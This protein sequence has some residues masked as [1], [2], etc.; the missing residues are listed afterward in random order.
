[1]AIAWTA[2]LFVLAG[3][4]ADIGGIADDTGI[5]L[6][7]R[8]GCDYCFTR[9]VGVSSYPPTADANGTAAS[10]PDSERAAHAFAPSRACAAYPGRARRRPQAT[11][12]RIRLS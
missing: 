6:E 4:I 10:P 11:L 3:A 5:L 8:R 9:A 12:A 7:Y 1:M 2:Y